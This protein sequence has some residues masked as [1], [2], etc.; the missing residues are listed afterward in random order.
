MPCIIIYHLGDE[1][2]NQAIKVIV[3]VMNKTLLI[4]YSKWCS[5]NNIIYTCCVFSLQSCP[6]LCGPMECNLPGSSAVEF[7]R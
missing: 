5:K 4:F 6:T 3:D 2:Q 7:S 1:I